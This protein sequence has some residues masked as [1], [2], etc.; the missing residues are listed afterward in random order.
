MGVP[1]PPLDQSQRAKMKCTDSRPPCDDRLTDGKILKRG[2]SSNPLFH[3]GGACAMVYARTDDP[4]HP[5]KKIM[6]HLLILR[7]K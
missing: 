2:A 5:M 7:R 1:S 3:T 6:S 4:D